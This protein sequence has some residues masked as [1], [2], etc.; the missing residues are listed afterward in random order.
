MQ[1]NP[2]SQITSSANTL[3][4]A[5][6]VSAKKN[7]TWDG[8]TFKVAD[9]A[10]TR[11]AAGRE[12]AGQTITSQINVTDAAAN[13]GAALSPSAVAAGGMT[14]VTFSSWTAAAVNAASKTLSASQMAALTQDPAFQAAFLRQEMTSLNTQDPLDPRIKRAWDNAVNSV[15]YSTG[16]IVPHQAY[17]PIGGNAN[18]GR[19]GLSYPGQ[20]SK[21]M[22]TTPS[23]KIGGQ[24]ITV[25]GLPSYLNNPLAQQALQTATG[26]MLQ[27]FGIKPPELHDSRL[28]GTS[29]PTT[30]VTQTPGVTPVPT[31]VSPT[32][33]PHGV[34]APAPAPAPMPTV[35][36]PPTAIGGKAIL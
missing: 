32:T 33:V 1:A 2:G 29:V 23:I 5:G 10:Y 27:P 20:Q 15:L 35:V 8:S 3:D 6:K 22:T 31:S 9:T 19:D 26:S 17:E 18:Q 25:P 34:P 14:G 4:K 24:T 21:A 30:T 11:D 12:V 13:V 36:K 7:I 16:M 28:P